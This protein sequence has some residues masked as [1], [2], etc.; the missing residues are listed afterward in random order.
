MTGTALTEA[1]EFWN[2]YKLDVI[3]VPTNRGLQ[4]TI[5][6]DVI[7]RSEREKYISIA[8]EIERLNKYDQVLKEDGELIT[9][10]IAKE[11]ENEI[12]IVPQNSKQPQTIPMR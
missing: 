12:T 5:Y 7:Y 8:D 2:I 6:P 11:T 4:R 3:G 1:G 10:T 9:G